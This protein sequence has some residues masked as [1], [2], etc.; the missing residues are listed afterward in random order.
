MQS[1]C[2][3]HKYRCIF[4]TKILIYYWRRQIEPHLIYRIGT[5]Q[6]GTHQRQTDKMVV[7]KMT[8]ITWPDIATQNCY[9]NTESLSPTSV[10]QGT[11]VSVGRWSGWDCT[12]HTH[13]KLT[14]IV[15]QGDARET[16]YKCKLTTLLFINDKLDLI[17]ID[18]VYFSLCI[19]FLDLSLSE[20][21]NLSESTRQRV[22]V[23]CKVLST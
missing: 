23:S 9:M 17:S 10:V 20:N 13:S 14:L 22:H 7:N 3:C 8:V 15:T 18:V 12:R 19:V 2:K 16:R 11:A 5:L 21:A 1:L 4:T 6:H